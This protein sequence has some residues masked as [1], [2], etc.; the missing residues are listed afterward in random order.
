MATAPKTCPICGEPLPP[1]DENEAFP[2][3]SSRCRL[4]DLGGWIDGDYKVP[5]PR[6]FDVPDDQ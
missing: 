2:F 6:T 5:G 3:C 1:R 4:I